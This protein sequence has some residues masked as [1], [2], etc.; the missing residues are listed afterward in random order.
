MYSDRILLSPVSN[1]E[2]LYL[3]LSVKDDETGD[4]IDMVALGWTFQFEIRFHGPRNTG[5]GYIP[6]YDWG[7][8]DDIG[9]LIKATLNAP[10]GAGTIIIDDIGVMHVR[11]PETL[12]RTL[13]SSTY[14]AAMTATDGFE[15][16]QLFIA[17]LSVLWGGVTV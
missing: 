4:L 9:P 12:M 6:W 15:T 7:T 11:I 16:R 1:R 3:P 8:P 13:S 2:D 10:A 14:Q 5:S 17:R